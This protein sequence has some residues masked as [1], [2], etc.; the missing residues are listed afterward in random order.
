MKVKNGEQRE[1]DHSSPTFTMFRMPIFLVATPLLNLP[2]TIYWQT[3]R[4]NY[5]NDRLRYRYM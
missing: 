1:L 2:R 5:E 4:M 3:F